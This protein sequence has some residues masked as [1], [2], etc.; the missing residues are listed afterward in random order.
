MIK[1]K[2]DPRDIRS[3]VFSFRTT[4]LGAAKWNAKIRSSGMNKSRF[5][6]EAITNNQ[7]VVSPPKNPHVPKPKRTT[8]EQKI[9]ALLNY[10]SVNINQIAHRIN[11]DHKSGGVK[12]YVY[13][14]ALD[15]LEE[16]ANI[17]KAWRI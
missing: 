9:I 6:D 8:D 4:K 11:S 14:D 10:I 7:T 3:V 12:E 15:A 13:V 17:A 2:K 16:I 1:P 5:F